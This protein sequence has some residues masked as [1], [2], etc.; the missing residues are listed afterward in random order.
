MVFFEGAFCPGFGRLGDVAADAI[1]L[2][3]F[4]GVDAV[5]AGLGA[6][7][8]DGMAPDVFGHARF[9]GL[10]ARVETVVADTRGGVLLLFTGGH[11]LLELGALSLVVTNF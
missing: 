11:R 9:G 5:G 1:A 7:G 6:V 3:G 4:S 10:I 8:L 2:N